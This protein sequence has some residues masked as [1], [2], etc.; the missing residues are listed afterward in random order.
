MSIQILKPSTNVQ[1]PQWPGSQHEASSTLFPNHNVKTASGE[2]LKGLHAKTSTLENPISPTGWNYVDGPRVSIL[3]P[4]VDIAGGKSTGKGL[5]GYVTYIPRKIWSLFASSSP[6]KFNVPQGKYLII[7]RANRAPLKDKWKLGQTFEFPGRAYN[8][9]I[10]EE[11]GSSSKAAALTAAHELGIEEK[12]NERLGAKLLAQNVSAAA[13]NTSLIYDF[14]SAN[15][16][17]EDINKLIDANGA[18]LDTDTGV[19]KINRK[20]DGGIIDGLELVPVEKAKDY[21]KAREEAKDSV[22]ASTYAAL[23]LI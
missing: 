4:Q 5:W 7:N 22:A 9:T 23:N 18:E 21:F 8:L 13:G 2:A 20:C 19:V 12:D 6:N 10:N 17:E 11:I 16:Q 3:I 1:P 14:Y 15:L